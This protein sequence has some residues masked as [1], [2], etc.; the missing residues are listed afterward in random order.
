MD[1][2]GDYIYLIAIAI[3]AISS[4][5]KKKKKKTE[6]QQ[7]EAGEDMFPDLDDVI[8]DIP[9]YQPE[10]VKPV[11][12]EVVFDAPVVNKPAARVL[13]YTEVLDNQLGYEAIND[14]KKARAVKMV[15]K[16]T[17]TEIK[18]LPGFEET[19]PEQPSEYL[20]QNEEEAKRAIIYAEIFN[21]KYS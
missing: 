12:Q 7:R 14:V 17:K 21:R 20:L 18:T 11:Y 19:E 2:F 6:E 1:D 3:A 16:I 8:P 9:E 15:N 4:I 13:D 10:K 5:L